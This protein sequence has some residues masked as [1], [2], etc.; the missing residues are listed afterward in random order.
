V[1]P[2]T[3]SGTIGLLAVLAGA[4]C[5]PNPDDLRPGGGNNGAGGCVGALCSGGKGGSTG[6][7]GGGIPPGADTTAYANAVCDRF[8]SCAPGRLSFAFGSLAACQTRFKLFIDSVLFVPNTGWTAA[9]LATC[10][11]AQRAQSCT[12]FNDGA[13]LPACDLPGTRTSGQACRNSNQCASLRCVFT[14]NLCGVCLPRGGAGA[15]CAIDSDCLPPRV[16]TTPYTGTGT[17]AMPVGAGAACDPASSPCR[18]S[19]ACLNGICAAP[20]RAQASCVDHQDCDDRQGYL[21]N[22]STLVCGSATASSTI[23]GAPATNGT[24]LYCPASGYCTDQF[25]CTAAAADNRSCGPTGPLCT[26]PASCI[27]G[28]CTLPSTTDCR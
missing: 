25:T 13:D 23:C 17:C 22:F 7:G 26:F 5:Y 2:V 19:L 15:S 6:A 8:Q 28:I 11:A 20:G 27:N 12:D 18:Y 1:D 9:N 21:C 24:L 4:G 14:D 3:R 10:A 16:C